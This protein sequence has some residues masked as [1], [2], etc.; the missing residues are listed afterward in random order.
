LEV[1]GETRD[2]GL[3]MLEWARRLDEDR[4]FVVAGWGEEVYRVH[5][6]FLWGGMH[7]FKTGSLQAYHFVARKSES[8]GPK[9]SIPRRVQPFLG[10]LR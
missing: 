9:P 3:T 7:A 10:N 6:L 1:V 8:P 2:Y 4:D 5:R